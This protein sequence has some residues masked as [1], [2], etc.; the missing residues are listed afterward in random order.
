MLRPGNS[1]SST[2]ADH[3]AVLTVAIRQIP[4]RMRS[5]VLVRVDGSAPATS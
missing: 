4:S 3:A 5:R 2:F 1:G